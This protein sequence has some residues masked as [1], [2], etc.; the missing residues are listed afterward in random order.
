MAVP[1]LAAQTLSLY[2]SSGFAFFHA[3]NE[4]MAAACLVLGNSARIKGSACGWYGIRAHNTV[5][6]SIMK[7]VSADAG[8]TFCGFRFVSAQA[9]VMFLVRPRNNHSGKKWKTRAVWDAGPATGP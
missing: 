4:V 7:R 6:S 1:N 9:S 5:L 2:S 3:S 8:A